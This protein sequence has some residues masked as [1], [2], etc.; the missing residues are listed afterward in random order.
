MRRQLAYLEYWSYHKYY[1]LEHLDR[2][3]IL[4]TASDKTPMM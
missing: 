3:V 1:S 4:A 2:L